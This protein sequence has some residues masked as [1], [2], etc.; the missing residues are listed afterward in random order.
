MTLVFTKKG[1]IWLKRLNDRLHTLL[2][3]YIDYL[4]AFVYG[5][6]AFFDLVPQVKEK[7]FLEM[8]LYVAKIKHEVYIARWIAN[9]TDWFY[10]IICLVRAAFL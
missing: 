3:H 5:Q 10:S 4:E 7:Y 6:N 2:K 9:N 1:N 8:L